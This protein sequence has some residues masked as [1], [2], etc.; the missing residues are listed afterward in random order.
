MAQISLI[1]SIVPK[2]WGDTVL[3]ASVAAGARGGTVLFG[4]GSGVNEKQKIFGIRIEPE[5]E[6]I[7]TLAEA[8]QVD[9]LV[10]A[11]VK[12]AKLEER[13]NGL[14]FVVPVEKLAGVSALA[15]HGLGESAD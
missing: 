12:A 15:L 13:G 2:G 3:E 9:A 14:T 8:D 6:I 5:K 4:R 7:L 1:V 11:I 10:A